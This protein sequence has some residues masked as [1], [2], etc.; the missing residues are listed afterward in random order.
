MK[1]DKL[2]T[3]GE[4]F[5]EDLLLLCHILVPKLSMVVLVVFHGCFQSEHFMAQSQPLPSFEPVERT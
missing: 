2:A 3:K 4:V 5:L 1:E